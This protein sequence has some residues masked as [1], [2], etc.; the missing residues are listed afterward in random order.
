MLIL[1]GFKLEIPNRQ[2]RECGIRFILASKSD[3][4][5]FT[6]KGLIRHSS[7]KLLGSPSFQGR[8]LWIIAE[9]SSLSLTEEVAFL[10]FPLEEDLREL[11][12][13]SPMVL[14]KHL[15]YP[16]RAESLF[17]HE[18]IV[19]LI[20]PQKG[21]IMVDVS[22]RQAH[23]LGRAVL[24]VFLG[25]VGSFA[26]V[27]NKQGGQLG[28]ENWRSWGENVLAPGGFPE[29]SKFSFR[30]LMAEDDSFLYHEVALLLVNTWLVSLHLFSIFFKFLRQWS[31]ELLKTEKSSMNT[32][33]LSSIS[34]WNM[35][36][37]QR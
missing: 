16:F 3:R 10:S 28:F 20:E 26:L 17:E 13:H 7:V 21:R 27:T 29:P 19:V 30:D 31:K 35:D 4:E 11:F 14:V 37:I 2:K 36:V 5:F 22:P 6:A 9:H 25:L 32:S 33:M 23:L 1:V 24:S 34:S 8:L 12:M 18:D 15:L